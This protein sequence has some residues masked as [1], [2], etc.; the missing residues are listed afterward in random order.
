[1]RWFGTALKGASIALVGNGYRPVAGTPPNAAEV[2]GTRD[3]NPL[4]LT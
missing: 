4:V 3:V 2:G 1:V